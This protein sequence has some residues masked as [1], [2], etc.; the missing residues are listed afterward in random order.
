MLCRSVLVLSRIVLCCTRAALVLYR[1]VLVLYRVILVL[2]RVVL[3]CTRVVSCFYL[4]SFLDLIKIRD[5][6]LII[7][8]PEIVNEKKHHLYDLIQFTKHSLPK[9]SFKKKN[10]CI[11]LLNS[12][13]LFKILIMAEMKYYKI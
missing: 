4:R 6:F 5:I 11:K 1:V 10:I 9:Y 13:H 8:F 3:C 12:S 7:L 2:S